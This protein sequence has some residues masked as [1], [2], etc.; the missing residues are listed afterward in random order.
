MVALRGAKS[1]LLTKQSKHFVKF[2]AVLTQRLTTSRQV[3]L[4]TTTAKLRHFMVTAHARDVSRTH[5]GKHLRKHEGCAF[6]SIRDLYPYLDPKARFSQTII[7]FY[8]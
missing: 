2:P 5:S 6:L 3:K 1:T 4:A 7:E 8:A